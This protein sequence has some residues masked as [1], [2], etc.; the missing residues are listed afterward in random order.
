[1]YRNILLKKEQ[2]IQVFS[3]VAAGT[4]P[5]PTS[6]AVMWPQPALAG[7]AWVWQSWMH[8]FM[9]LEARMGFPVSTLLK[10]KAAEVLEV[11][12]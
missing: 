5:K 10:S 1:M 6:G 9:Q 3:L 4:I 8:F 7:P 11:Q 2:W 12:L